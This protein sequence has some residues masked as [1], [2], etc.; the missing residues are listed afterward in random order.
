MKRVRTVIVALLLAFSA[1]ANAGLTRNMGTDP[2]PVSA[3]PEASCNLYR[4]AAVVTNTPV[5][6]GVGTVACSFPSVSL[7]VGE[8][9]TATYVNAI[10]FE[11]AASVPFATGSA[12]GKPNIVK[13][14]P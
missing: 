14:V 13:I 1:A 10:G 5:V 6:A 12:P 11:G 7:N 8:S 4:G 3:T 9:Y 2:T